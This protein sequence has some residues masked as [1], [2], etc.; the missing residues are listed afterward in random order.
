MKSN[1]SQQCQVRLE[2]LAAAFDEALKRIHHRYSAWCA[3][4]GAF[5]SIK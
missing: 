3:I 5:G 4:S 2:F 1:Q